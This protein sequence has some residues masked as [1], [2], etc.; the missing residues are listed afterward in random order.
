[1]AG[2]ALSALPLVH[3]FVQGEMGVG[4]FAFLTSILAVIFLVFFALLVL[5]WFGF[6]EWARRRGRKQALVVHLRPFFRP[7]AR[8]FSWW[9]PLRLGRF[10][11]AVLPPDPMA[12]LGAVVLLAWLSAI[13]APLSFFWLYLPLLGPALLVSPFVMTAVLWASREEVRLVRF[14]VVI[15]YWVHRVPHDAEFAEFWALEDPAPSGLAF[16][17]RSRIGYEL[18]LGTT[19]SAARLHRHISDVLERTGWKPHHRGVGRQY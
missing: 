15:P 2:C 6:N 12:A 9:H 19:M 16:T 14:F 5:P 10:G 13:V 4:E 17:S 18:L 8:L 1:M 3:S 7:V 11:E